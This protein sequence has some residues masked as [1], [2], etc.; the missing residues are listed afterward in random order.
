MRT[1]RISK[2]WFIPAVAFLVVIIAGTSM[3][4]GDSSWYDTV[5]KPS[6]NPPNEIFGPVWSLLYILIAISAWRAWDCV[7][8]KDHAWIL[9]LFSLNA[10]LNLAWTPLFFG[11]HAIDLALLDA[12]LLELTTVAMIFVLWKYDKLAAVLLVP[13]LLWVGFAIYL[14]AVLLQLNW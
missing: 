12:V 14:N 5:I 2:T 4:L 8:K 11:L 13:Y 3:S 6:W 1:R 10:I 7:T 9:T